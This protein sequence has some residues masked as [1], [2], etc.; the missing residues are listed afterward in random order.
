MFVCA[1]GCVYVFTYIR[2]IADEFTKKDLLV[3]VEGIDDEA[4]KLVDLCLE[5]KGLSLSHPNIS[6]C[7]LI[8]FPY[9]SKVTK[10]HDQIHKT[11]W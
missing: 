6:H 7:S 5:R 1:C 4:Q 3:A 9:E 8:N 11:E 2:G 10:V